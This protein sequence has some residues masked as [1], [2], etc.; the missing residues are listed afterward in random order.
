[1]ANLEHLAVGDHL[2][3]TDR[4][5]HLDLWACL[6]PEV[7]REKRENVDLP[8]SWDPLDHQVHLESLPAMML[9][10]CLLS[11]VKAPPRAL[12]P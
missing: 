11:S 6:V 4:W 8:V 7:R 10:L 1:M 3:L 9:Q 5:V 2:A 12:I